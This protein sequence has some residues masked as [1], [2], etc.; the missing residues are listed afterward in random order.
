MS[1]VSRYEL[2]TAY[3]DCID[4]KRSTENVIKFEINENENI[5]N[6][7]KKLNIKQYDIGKSI[8]FTLWNK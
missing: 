5:K 1:Y 3:E 8:V 6:I 7:Y 2:N 4:K